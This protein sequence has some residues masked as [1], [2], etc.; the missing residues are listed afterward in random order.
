MARLGAKV[1]RSEVS[2]ILKTT[3]LVGILWWNQPHTSFLGLI[4]NMAC[5]GVKLFRTKTLLSF[6]SKAL[7]N[8][9]FQKTRFRFELLYWIAPH[10]C[11]WPNGLDARLGAKVSRSEVSSILKTTFLVGIL[12]WNRPH[13]SFL[14]LIGYMVRSWPK[15]FRTKTLLSFASKSPLKFVFPKNTFSVW[16]FI[17]NRAS[18]IFLAKRTR[19]HDWG[20]KCRGAKFRPS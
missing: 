13:T 9:F 12:W 6:A 1:S 14:G 5:S 18:P 17:L 8:S 10:L 15:L 2:S 4:G 3:F 7:S 11:S 19:W 20:Q 16:I